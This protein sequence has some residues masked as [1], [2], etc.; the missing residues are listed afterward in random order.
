[1]LTRDEAIRKAMHLA[2]D[3]TW[4]VRSEQKEDDNWAKEDK[5]PVTIA[6]LASQ[7][8]LLTFIGETYPDDYVFA[9]ES[10]DSLSDSVQIERVREIVEQTTNHSFSTGE[11]YERLNYRGNPDSNAKW[12]VDPLDG[13]KGFVKGLLYAVAIGR[14]VDNVLDRTWLAV[15]GKEGILPVVDK[16][17][18]AVKGQGAKMCPLLEPDNIT[19]MPHP[20]VNM[21]D[22][23]QVVG[24]RAHGG[25]SLPKP[26]E[27]AGIRAKNYP[28]DSQAK[29]A[30]IAMGIG[31]IY[32][33]NP[34]PSYGKF[35]MWDHVPGVLIVEET[36]GVVTDMNGKPLDWSTGE[37]LMN[38]EGILA[39]ASKEMHAKYQPLFRLDK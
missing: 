27:E 25:A 11:I 20:A 9:E 15:P 2:A 37:R 12:Y 10:D 5:T 33:R 26:I 3:A 21:D 18:W 36:G 4:M 6:D 35:Y 1:M 24:S 34:S 7:V 23:L 13:T 38:N 16:L 32:P 30:A 22:E 39:A 14:T 17:Y 31:H 19:D 8:I 29:Y 28:V